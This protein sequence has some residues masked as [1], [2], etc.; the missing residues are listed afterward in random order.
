MSQRNSM[1]L[2]V[3][4]PLSPMGIPFNAQGMKR[5][6]CKRFGCVGYECTK[7]N[8]LEGIQALEY[9]SSMYMG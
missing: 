9:P 4:N 5:A 7:P 1:G 2:K 8:G 6:Y 3:W